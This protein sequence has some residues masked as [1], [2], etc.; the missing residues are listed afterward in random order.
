MKVSVIISYHN[1]KIFINECLDSLE[2]QINKDFEAIVVC[3]HSSEEAMAELR[4]H[5]VS[6]PLTIL[7]LTDGSGVAAARNAGI[8]A[9]QG[10]YILFLD[11]DDYLEKT[12]LDRTL[13]MG[14]SAAH[15][16]AARRIMKIFRNRKKSMTQRRRRTR[17][18]RH[19]QTEACRRS[20][21]AIPNGSRY[22]AISSGPAA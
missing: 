13:S 7:E 20:G 16:T 9:S 17:R 15:G 19:R 6:F 22:S 4:A 2:E 8:R 21:R 18:K 5:P 3:D 1:E 10:E 12:A 14:A 11:C